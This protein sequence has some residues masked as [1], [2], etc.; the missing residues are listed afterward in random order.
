[1]YQPIIFAKKI[2]PRSEFPFH[3]MIKPVGR[4]CNLQCQY[5]YY[6]QLNNATSKVMHDELIEAL[7][8]QYIYAQPTYVKEINFVWQGGEPLLA[9]KSFYHK[10]FMW[11][12]KYARNDVVITNTFQTNGCLLDL[13]WIE[14]FK[15]Q[16]VVLG[17]SLDGNEKL[18]NQF[19][20][21][22]KGQG[23]YGDV[24]QA[25]KLCQRYQL[26]FNILTV[27]H[28]GMV[29][30]VDEIYAH[31]I[32]LG[33]S[34]VQF[35]PLIT[36]GLAI[37]NH[38]QLSSYS[39][40]K[41]LSRVYTI[42]KEHKDRGRIFF[43][44]IEEVYFQ[45]FHQFSSSCVHAERCGTNLACDNTGQLFACDHLMDSV[46]Y[47]DKFNHNLNLV[48]A[49]YRSS[50]YEFGR[51]KSLRKECQICAVKNVC[52][53]GCPVHLQD[54]RNRLC[55]GYFQFFSL[56]LADLKPYPRNQEGLIRWQKEF[57]R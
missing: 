46:H 7:I 54:N 37:E 30:Y 14:F 57:L 44:N 16:K 51:N 48:N 27:I 41:F 31:F 50:Q 18:H 38:F 47:L 15:D 26:E 8:K 12:K 19:R 33:I 36:D 49:V 22:K 53:G 11:Q 45:Y 34:V 5:C 42:W 43:T 2:K 29:D 9:G 17:I 40:G 20:Y 24:I 32:K 23:S 28:D 10:V 1:M 56:I 4:A 3:I 6:P 55:N 25:V 13:E 52:Q 39:W 21:S 35:Q